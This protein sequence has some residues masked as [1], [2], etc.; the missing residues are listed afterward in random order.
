VISRF[1][2]SARA[3]GEEFLNDIDGYPEQKGRWGG[4]KGQFGQ[5]KAVQL[6]VERLYQKTRE[7]IASWLA[8]LRSISAN[9]PRRV[10]GGVFSSKLR[11]LGKRLCVPSMLECVYWNPRLCSIC[12]VIMFFPALAVD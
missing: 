10:E 9:L 3:V 5:C 8:V 12:T 6:L 7:S 1:L 4:E 2:K 11:L